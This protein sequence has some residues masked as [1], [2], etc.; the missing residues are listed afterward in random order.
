[1]QSPSPAAA[2]GRTSRAAP[3]RLLTRS[4]EPLHLDTSRR[5]VR[6]P[7][8]AAP[9]PRGP[10]FGLSAA[11]LP[12]RSASRSRASPARASLTGIS[13]SSS[14]PPQQPWLASRNFLAT[15]QH[16]PARKLPRPQPRPA[17]APANP[18]PRPRCIRQSGRL[19]LGR[20]GGLCRLRYCGRGRRAS[21]RARATGPGA[22]PPLCYTE[23]RAQDE[24]E[25]TRCLRL[26]LCLKCL[27]AGKGAS[28]HPRP[29]GPCP[30]HSQGNP[31]VPRASMYRD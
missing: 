13:G 10:D 2:R 17:A 16:G 5:P 27:T 15:C 30:L 6:W 1:M 26:G 29:W 19:R 7:P 8:P 11:S 28:Y 20:L 14:S 24:A 25:T 18:P 9:S 23:D 21:P 3:G 22:A 12:T 4:G 31:N